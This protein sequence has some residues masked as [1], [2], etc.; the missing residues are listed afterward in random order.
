MTDKTIKVVMCK[1]GP[2]SH[3]IGIRLVS[4]WFRDAGMEVAYLGV[5]LKV[6]EV[7]AAAIQ[8]D[9]DVIGI[10]FFSSGH[11]EVMQRLMSQL[12]E[13]GLYHILIVLGGVIP[14]NDIPKLKEIGVSNVFLHGATSEE[15]ISFVQE[16][17]KMR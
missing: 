17:V 15:M 3:D 8:E 10:N 6:D 7:V 2:D 9:A 16:N 13:K 5:G 4:Q 12:R 1:I 14:E 11:L